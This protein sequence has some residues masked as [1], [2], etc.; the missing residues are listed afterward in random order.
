M[1]L[2][3]KPQLALL[4]IDLHVLKVLTVALLDSSEAVGLCDRKDRVQLDHTLHLRVVNGRSGRVLTF[5]FDFE[6]RS[7]VG[8][9]R[10]LGQTV[11][12]GSALVRLGLAVDAVGEA[13]NVVVAWACH[14]HVHRY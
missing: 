1:A 3:D 4:L 11:G 7:K 5:E 10:L 8:L 9:L 12:R 2:T 6:G 14:V 13:W